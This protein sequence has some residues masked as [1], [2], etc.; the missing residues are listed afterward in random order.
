[1]VNIKALTNLHGQSFEYRFLLHTFDIV[2]SQTNLW[3]TNKNAKIWWLL[4]G[5]G[6]LWEVLTIEL[7]LEQLIWGSPIGFSGFGIRVFKATWCDIRVASI[8]SMEDSNNNH[9]GIT[10]FGSVQFGLG[11]RDWRTLLGN[12]WL[13]YS[14]WASFTRKGHSQEEST[15]QGSTLVL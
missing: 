3:L 12:L 8:Q 6:R 1:M 9:R 14:E 10:G 13:D 11:W 5:D 7:S 4:I 2:Y 15:D